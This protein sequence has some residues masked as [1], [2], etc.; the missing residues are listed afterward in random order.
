[1]GLYYPYIHFRNE[2][3][4]K[5][6]ALYWPRIARVV[7]N[8]YRV[9]DS[10]TTAIL[11]DELD[12]VV[13]VPPNHS[14]TAV[15]GIFTE[16][17]E[18][19]TL[20]RNQEF[21]VFTSDLAISPGN[22][23]VADGAADSWLPNG[24]AEAY[25]PPPSRPLRRLAGVYRDEVAPPLR[26]ALTQAGLALETTRQ[27]HVGTAARE[28]GQ[29]LAMDPSLAWAYK[30][31]LTE[32]LARVNELEPLTDG[33]AAYALTRPW[34]VD[35]VLA[36]LNEPDS[37]PDGPTDFGHLQHSAVAE[38]TATRVAML[39]MQL[40]V[41]QDLTAVPAERIVAVRKRCGAEFDAFRDAVTTAAGELTELPLESADPAVV[42]AYLDQ[43]VARRFEQPLGNLRSAMRGLNMETALSAA[44]MK[45]EL[46]AAAAALGG[47]VAGQP[48][49]ATAGGLAFAMVGLGHSW[50]Q[51]WADRRAASPES[52]LLRVGKGLRP[53][54]LLARVLTPGRHERRTT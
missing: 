50:K 25:G 18:R 39:A 46:P 16:A 30:C 28:T 53:R 6:A 2:Q 51:G 5:L 49:V 43:I 26:E 27:I 4:L 10:R 32:H 24:H 29:W 8:G 33:I 31:A 15:A 37:M 40:V 9:R 13:S 54:S 12:F 47:T 44:S 36:L 41:P 22:Q 21:R 45:F 42:A 52:Y 23:Y 35:R 7:P 19:H 48:A 34:T 17:I 1:M 20:Q 11:T 38:D 14:A 3:W